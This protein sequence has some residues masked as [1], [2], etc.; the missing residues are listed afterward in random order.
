M[1]KLYFLLLLA[2]AQITTSAKEVIYLK[3]GSIIKGD[4]V[5]IIP[6]KTLTVETA[7]GSSFVCNYDDIDKITRE[8]TENNEVKATPEPKQGNKLSPLKRGYSGDVSSG[9]FAGEVWGAD[10]LTT[11]GFRFNP[12][13]FIGLGTGVRFSDYAYTVSIPVF[14]DFR[15]DV[16]K[17]KISPFIAVKSGVSIDLEHT[18]ATGFYG[19]GDVGCRF[20]RFYVSTGFETARAGDECTSRNYYWDSSNKEIRSWTGT[21]DYG[22]QAFSFALRLG[23][24]F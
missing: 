9:F 12:N 19:A 21:Y 20:G 7:D 6:N 15:Y 24:V 2:A 16:L 17:Y 5:E 1:R 8:K 23:F 14:V 4:I 13:L 3:N 18:I 22:F 11:H 10:I